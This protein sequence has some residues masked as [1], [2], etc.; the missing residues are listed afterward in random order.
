M[1]IKRTYHKIC[2]R[3]VDRTFMG[4]SGKCC[5]LW[6]SS[7]TNPLSNISAYGT[8]VPAAGATGCAEA[9]SAAALGIAP[10]TACNFGQ[11]PLK[12]DDDSERR[13]SICR[14]VNDSF[15]KVRRLVFT[16]CSRIS[17][18]Q[19]RRHVNAAARK[20]VCDATALSRADEF[21][22]QNPEYLRHAH[23][24]LMHMESENS[25]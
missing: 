13:R 23:A 25:S 7:G 11:P 4:S 21:G 12:C 2:M 18:T 14:R 1:F 17:W 24:M 20:D 6:R 5:S 22:V 8:C 15:G 3:F 19:R 9:S 10:G 16:P